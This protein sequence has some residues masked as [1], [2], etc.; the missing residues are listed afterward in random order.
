VHRAPRTATAHRRGFPALA[1]IHCWSA[2]TLLAACSRDEEPSEPPP[3]VIDECAGVPAIELVISPARTRVGGAV[4]L[5]ASGGTGRYSYTLAAGGSGGEL[6]GARLIAGAMLGRDTVTVNDDCD[7]SASATLEVAAA[8]SVSPE[9]AAVRPGMAFTIRVDGALGE[10]RF[11]GQSL[12]SDGSVTDRGVYTAGSHAGLD[13]I[14]VRDLGT[15]EE[16]LVEVRVDPEA[17]LRAAPSLLALPAGASAPLVTLDGSGVTEWRK[18][19]GPG[20][21]VSGEFRTESSASGLAELIGTDAFTGETVMIRVQVLEEL[22]RSA[23]PHGRLTDVANLVTG[24]FDGDGIQDVALGVPESD[25]GRPTGGAVF[26]FKGSREGLPSAPTWVLTGDSDTAGLGTVIAA[27]DLDGDGQDDLAVSEPGADVTVADSGAVLLYKFGPSGPALLRSPLT[28][29]GRGNFGASLAIADVDGD[30]DADLIVGSPGADLA[31]SNDIKERGVVD[32]FLLQRG[33]AISDLGSV[34]IGGSD[35][36]ADGSRK[37]ASGLRFGRAVAVADWNQDGRADLAS[38]GSVNNSLVGGTALAKNQI[39]IA[40]HFGRDAT[41]RF[42]ETPDLYVLPGNSLDGSEGT[43]R[44]AAAPAAVGG[45]APRLLLS[46]DK[47]D[48]PDLTAAGGGKGGGDAGGV[49]LFDLASQAVQDVAPQQ[50]V[51]L[52]RNDALARV[53]GDSGGMAAGRSVA[54]ADIDGDGTLELVLGAPNASGTQ[55]QADK[56]LPVPLA[57]K[58]LVYPYAS[59]APGAQLNKPA[60]VRPGAGAID[61]LGVA[62]AAWAPDGAKGVLAYAARASTSLGAFTGRLEA[63]LGSGKLGSFARSTVEIPARVASQQHGA[64]VAIG[65]IDGR[66]QALVGMPGYSGPGAKQDGN[67]LGAGR[68]LRYALG[69]RDEP[70]VVHEGASSAYDD[71]GQAA[72]GGKGVGSDVAF[73]DWNGDGR[74]DLVVAAP[75]LSTPTMNNT[76]YA[77]SKP[78]CVTSSGQGNGGA[79]IQLAQAD[80]SFKP[81][82]RVF[83]VADIPGCTPAGDAKCKRKELA[84]AGLAGGFDFDGDGKQDLLVTRANGL[85][86]FLGRDPDDAGLAKPTM[87]CDPTFSLPALAQTVSAPAVLGDLDRDGCDEVSV[88]YSD[89]SRSGVLIAFGFAAGGGRCGGH[90]GPA[91]LRISGDAEKGLNNLQLGVASARAGRLLDDAREFVAISAAMFPLEGVAQP[92]VLLFDTAQLAAK[93]PASGEAVVGAL[94]DSLEPFAVAYRERAPGFGRAIAGDVDFDGDGVVD[95]VVSAPGA[96]IN[97]DGTG[98]VFA[99]RGGKDFRGRLEPWLTVLG[100]GAERASVGADLAAT[101][102]KSGAR[103]ALVIGAPLSYRTGTANG[104]AW[105]LP[106]GD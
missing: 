21:V 37:A 105:L 24:D 12:G 2:L 63:Y 29:L 56:D 4:T 99:F 18:L 80:G 13:L 100:D 30:S 27:G 52:G 17:Q 11:S 93:R 60:D 54:V 42:A 84:K 5:K 38:L 26:V 33:Q 7:N 10:V 97:G 48:S 1:A 46:A 70:T 74:L 39:A 9:R 53:W 86:I 51:Q 103:A 85:E 22:T 6:R 16:A 79:L 104:T 94:N 57:G 92:S 47:L 59:L 75:Q 3:P 35:L 96:S 91:W 90:T 77:M 45:G 98:A 19:A 73:T 71:D 88:R 106:L 83:A 62:V 41:P 44:M 69:D 95:L 50:P 81:A 89:N 25:L 28:G 101:A 61:T 34:R 102:A 76:E 67:E 72:F 23:K 68:A 43:W 20:E 31:P 55:K 8:F 87:A 40:V 32:I 58:L 78:A 66:L 65:V 82:F 15:G 14:A 36:A 49:Y 64:A